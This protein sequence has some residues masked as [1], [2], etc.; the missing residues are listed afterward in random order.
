M[1]SLATPLPQNPDR[2]GGKSLDGYVLTGGGVGRLR[3]APAAVRVPGVARDIR[4]KIASEPAEWEAAFRLVADVYRAR[5]YEAP[6]S[7]QFR[8]TAHHALPDTTTFV[9]KEGEAV[10]GTLSLVSDNWL[11]GLP[12]EVVYG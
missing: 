8:F 4:V 6:D 11:V 10:V 2:H 9:A 7:G 12:L 1:N 3:A 5:G